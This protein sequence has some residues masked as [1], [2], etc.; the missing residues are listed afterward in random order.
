M[1]EEL[2]SHVQ[3]GDTRRDTIADTK[4]SRA[5]TRRDN[6]IIDIYLSIGKKKDNST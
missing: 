5:S 4:I 2:L 1:A 6:W 3:H